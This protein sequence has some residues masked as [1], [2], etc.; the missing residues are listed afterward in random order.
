MESTASK[1]PLRNGAHRQ[2]ETCVRN[3][4]VQSACSKIKQKLLKGLEEK[5]MQQAPCSCDPSADSVNQI[6]EQE[7]CLCERLTIQTSESLAAISAR[8]PLISLM[9]GWHC[10]CRSAECQTKLHALAT[11]KHPASFTCGLFAKELSEESRK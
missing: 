3:V 2:S 7:E 5:T 4:A 6:S 8:G 9:P 11:G 10:T 1:L